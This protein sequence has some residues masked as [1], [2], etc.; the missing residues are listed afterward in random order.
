MRVLVVDDEP[1]IRAL[2]ADTLSLDFEV[3][4]AA[5][6]AEALEML[7]GGDRYHCL[8]LDVMMPGLSG[9]EVLHRVRG[10]RV[11][12]RTAIVMLTAKSGEYDHL[13]AFRNGA[14]AY[15]TKP[16]DVDNV[17]EVVSE[18]VA[19][20]LSLRIDRRRAELDRADLLARIESSFGR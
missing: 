15:L 7:H 18:V 14:D 10:N 9:L 17:I 6:G 13:H 12:D 5:D 3:H 4:E 1:H 8:L 11:F 16:F 2:V 19:L 20:P